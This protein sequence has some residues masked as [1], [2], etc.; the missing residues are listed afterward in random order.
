MKKMLAISALMMCI[1]APALAQMTE[2]PQ[3]A[4]N[5]PPL[6]S[7][8]APAVPVSPYASGFPALPPSRPCTRRDILGIWKLL[9]LYE[10]PAGSKTAE[11][12]NSPM[13]YLSFDRDS[14]YGEVR[15]GRSD[16]TVQGVRDALVNQAADMPQFVAQESGFV[17]FYKKS[18]AVDTQACFIVVTQEGNFM[19]GQML[20][21]PPQ[22]QHAGRLVRS[23]TKI[24]EPP[25]PQRRGRK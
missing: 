17:Y 5:L 21:M 24:W 10:E 15:A 12:Q 25:A 20:L 9:A 23:Y 11:Y 16:L 6:P 8:A 2:T 18:I 22:G 1:A 7:A 4:Q 19:P 3:P 14:T 13:Q